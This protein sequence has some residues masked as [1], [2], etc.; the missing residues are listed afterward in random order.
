MFDMP[1]L[2]N[3]QKKHVGTQ[4]SGHPIST[5]VKWVVVIHLHLHAGNSSILGVASGRMMA[6]KV[7]TSCHVLSG[8]MPH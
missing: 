1:N 5:F 7:R 8:E 2:S 3:L 4:H 6:G